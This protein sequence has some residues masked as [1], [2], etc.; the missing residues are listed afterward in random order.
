MKG[1]YLFFAFFFLLINLYGQNAKVIIDADT[2]N[3]IDDMPAIVM[4]IKSGKIDVVALTASQWNR[5]EVC[6]RQTMLES[7][8]FNNRILKVLDLEHI[9][10]LK[11]AEYAVGQ[12]QW[13][14]KKPNEASDFIVKKAMEMPVGEKLIVI[15]SGPST[16]MATAI[17]AEPKI[18][19]RIAVY[20]IGTFYNF[21]SKAF[22]KNE[23]NSRSDLNAID[24]L[25]NTE[26]LELHVVP[27]N[28]TAKLLITR[29]DIDSRLKSDDGVEGMLKELWNTINK[30][31]VD[32]RI[33]WDFAIMQAVLNPHWTKQIVCRTPPENTPRDIHVYTEIETQ[34]MMDDFWRV[35]LK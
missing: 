35:F 15:V 6:G 28:V 20:F 1:F 2:G 7:W 5:F 31:N 19:E 22:N 32:W 9:P 23:P 27:A 21:D 24:I 26:N 13:G 11:G 8:M 25:F 29:K 34:A 17:Q 30:D 3:D 18:I 4:A 33:M 14:I 16:N 12:E 10:S